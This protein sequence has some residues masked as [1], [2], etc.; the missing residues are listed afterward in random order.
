MRPALADDARHKHAFGAPVARIHFRP[1]R[2]TARGAKPLGT[3]RSAPVDLFGAT[4]VRYA[5]YNLVGY[6]V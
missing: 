4:R 6:A 5:M 3:L 1:P 2:M